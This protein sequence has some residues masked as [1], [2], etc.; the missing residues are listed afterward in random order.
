MAGAQR[1][2]YRVAGFGTHVDYKV[3]DFI[4]DVEDVYVCSF[5]GVVGTYPNI[6]S[7]LH[8]ACS[9]CKSKLVNG[10]CLI[11]KKTYFLC[12]TVEYRHK[13]PYLR[14]KKVRCLNADSGCSFTGPLSTL[15][16]HLTSSCDFYV[17]T[18]FEC[19]GAIVF[20]DMTNHHIQC[21]GRGSDT[22]VLTAADARSLLEDFGNARNELERALDSANT[23][24][25]DELRAAVASLSEQLARLR[26]QLD[27][28]EADSG[29]SGLSRPGK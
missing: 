14:E 7:C 17:T 9:S 15:D 12:T 21:K 23:D 13:D 25:R 6:L 18:C 11:D 8:V 1:R 20:K 26:S 22:V 24:C 29:A 5:C 10:V 19:A 2:K 16:G 27:V 28:P 4:D 3:V